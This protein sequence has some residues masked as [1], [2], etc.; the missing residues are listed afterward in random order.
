MKLRKDGVKLSKY[1]EVEM[2]EERISV[3]SFKSPL[4]E[5]KELWLFFSNKAHRVK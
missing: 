4:K 2:E 3:A 5:A 1:Q